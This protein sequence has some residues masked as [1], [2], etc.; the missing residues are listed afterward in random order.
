MSDTYTNDLAK[1]LVDTK[2]WTLS[3]PG[4]DF[5]QLARSVKNDTKSETVS[6][7][8]AIILVHHQIMHELTKNLI[9]MATLYIQGEIWPTELSPSYD[10]NDE[11]MTG[12]YI[13]YLRD[14]CIEFKH[15]D[16][17]LKTAARLNAIRNKVAHDLTGK[18]EV[19]IGRSYSEFEKLFSELYAHHEKCENGLLNLLTDL[20]KRV[21]FEEFIE[22]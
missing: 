12:W 14:H 16:D 19:I 11:K 2:Q 13:G 22:D 5:L 4:D 9:Y 17:Y 3:P 7:K 21:D 18:N 1:R 20:T 10:N 15:K 6:S 8:I